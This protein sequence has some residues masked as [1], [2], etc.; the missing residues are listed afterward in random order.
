MRRAYLTLV[1]VCTSWG[2]IPFVARRI[3]LPAAAIVFGRVWVAAVALGLIILL[4]RDPAAPRLLSVRPWLCVGAGLILAVHWTAMFAAYQRAPAATVIF[5][6]FLAPVGIAL[7]A[8]RTIG[9]TVNRRTIGALALALAGFAL[10]AGPTR[11]ALGSAGLAISLLAGA[12]F[13]VLVLVSKPLAEAYGGLRAT[14]LEMAIAGTV[15]IPVAA[16][17]AW[18]S[19]RASWLWL[20]VL[21]VAH[22]AIGTALYLGALAKVPATHTGILGYLEPVGVVA[23]AWLIDG[24]RPTSAIVL[25]GLLVV[26]AGALVIRASAAPITPEV[27][28]SVPG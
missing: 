28:A 26:T 2:T 3:P 1:A 25:G 5:I 15:L 24:L 17:A 6:V 8:P 9:E 20:V 22:T 18:G 7:L 4:R 13:V 21:G 27:P 14:F 11:H 10:V 23:F 12:T 19:P 16:R